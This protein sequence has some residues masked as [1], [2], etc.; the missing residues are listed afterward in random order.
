LEIAEL[1]HRPPE[2][3]AKEFRYRCAQTFVF[4]IPV[5]ALQ[6][7]GP[8]LGGA[9]S[10]RWIALLQALL[11]GWIIYIAAAG[12]LFEG[13]VAFAARTFPDLLVSALSIIIYIYSVAC[14][15]AILL[16][17]RTILGIPRFHWC[18]LLLMAWTSLRWCQLSR[19]SR[20]AKSL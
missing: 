3:R 1:L 4:G 13:I 5:L 12:M 16:P 11:S 6:W 17:H 2:Q 7:I 20:T 9:E 19:R 14:A 8:K 15:I 18:V 10:P